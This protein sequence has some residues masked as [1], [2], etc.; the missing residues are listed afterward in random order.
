HREEATFGTVNFGDRSRGGGE[1]FVAFREKLVKNVSV[2]RRLLADRLDQRRP[3][4]FRILSSSVEEWVEAL[5][6]LLRHDHLPKAGG[7]RGSTAPKI[8]WAPGTT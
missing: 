7:R 6:L 8:G 2:V 5:Q 4:R 3:Y 1:S